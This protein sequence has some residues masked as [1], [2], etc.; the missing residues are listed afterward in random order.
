VGDEGFLEQV[1]EKWRSSDVGAGDL[2]Q[3]AAMIAEM[4]DIPPAPPQETP[5]PTEPR[6]QDSQLAA[7]MR[8]EA[9]RTAPAAAQPAVPSWT[10]ARPTQTPRKENF[11]QGAGAAHATRERTAD[12]A[13]HEAVPGAALKS[14]RDRLIQR[15]R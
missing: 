3:Q 8:E 13:G 5:R 4:T 6:R 15:Q 14:L 10:P 1:V 7:R 12:D 9:Q 2:M 11:P